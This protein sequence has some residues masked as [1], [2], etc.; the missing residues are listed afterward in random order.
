MG[1]HFQD[2]ADRY[3]PTISGLTIIKDEV[4]KNV[5]E[6]KSKYLSELTSAGLKKKLHAWCK[7][8]NY[9]LEDRIMVN[10]PVLDNYGNVVKEG[11]KAKMKTTEH[12]RLTFIED[13]ELEK[14]NEFI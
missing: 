8:N 1:R 4:L 11:A 6:S 14:E 2:W 10:V 7:V 13:E 3:I 9:E 12:I 5:Q